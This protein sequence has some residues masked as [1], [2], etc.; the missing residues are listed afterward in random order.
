MTKKSVTLEMYL[1]RKPDGS[2]KLAPHDFTEG[3]KSEYWLNEYGACMGKVVVTGEYEDI[4]GDPVEKLIEG[5]EASIERE[6]ADS[7]VRVGLMLDRINQLKCITHES[8]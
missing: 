1:H 8:N 4:E 5:L 3:G 7:Q 6:R 2:E